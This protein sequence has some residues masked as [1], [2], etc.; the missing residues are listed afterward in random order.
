[1]VRLVCM[2][3]NVKIHAQSLGLPY[4]QATLEHRSTLSSEFFS[5]EPKEIVLNLE[6]IHIEHAYLMTNQQCG[7]WIVHRCNNCQMVTHATQSNPDEKRVLVSSDLLSDEQMINRLTILP[8]Y[9]PLFKVV[10][11]A[12]SE[13]IPVAMDWAP[14]EV[15]ETLEML[16]MKLN[17]FLVTEEHAMEERIREYQEQEHNGYANLQTKVKNDKNAIINTVLANIYKNV[18]ESLVEAMKESPVP[19]ENDMMSSSPLTFGGVEMNKSPDDSPLK[20]PVSRIKSGSGWRSEKPDNWMPKRREAENDAV[21][22]NDD[23]F[24]Y[25]PGFQDDPS[26]LPF[27]ESDEEQQ[28]DTDDSATENVVP[29]SQ[30]EASAI[31]KFSTS[32]PI[33]VPQWGRQISHHIDFDDDEIDAAPKDAE[34]MAASIQAL[35]RSIHGDSSSV[36][37]EL[38]TSRTRAR[39]LSSQNSFQ[40]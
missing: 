5:R 6:G 13:T 18:S 2:C 28:H 12:N 22:D 1:M 19:P 25:D 30:S 32:V 8:E 37:G 17:S 24:Q 7:P 9:S 27:S 29:S 10:V 11:R 31:G 33:T 38:P 23:V 4:N 26:E 35:A 16:Q 15:N 39:V 36:F 34:T 40:Y 21:V 3:L 14:K 20:Y